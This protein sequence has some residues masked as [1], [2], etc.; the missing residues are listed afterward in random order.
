MILNRICVL[1][2]FVMHLHFS[3]KKIKPGNAVF[4]SISGL[5]SAGDERIELP[6]KVL[7]TP[8]IPFDQ[9]P[10]SVLR[11]TLFLYH[12]LRPVSMLLFSPS[13]RKAAIATD[14]TPAYPV[15]VWFYSHCK[16]P[17]RSLTFRM[18]TRRM[19][20]TSPTDL[21][22]ERGRMTVVNPSLRA[23]FTLSGA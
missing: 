23:S 4:I 3:W 20:S 21:T 22:Q 15:P 9:S 8:I 11:T 19:P 7:E 10:V 6:P 17:A 13:H 14:H 18:P 12:S 2:H 16:A 1:M 5:F